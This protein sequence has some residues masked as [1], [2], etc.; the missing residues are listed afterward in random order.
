MTLLLVGSVVGGLILY[1][2]HDDILI[3]S[4]KLYTKIHTYFNKSENNK[5]INSTDIKIGDQTIKSYN[6]N[7]KIFYRIVKDTND[8][9]P[10]DD[11][12]KNLSIKM[13]PILSL[14]LNINETTSID[15][16][17]ISQF[18]FLEQIIELNKHNVKFWIDVNNKLKNKD[19]ILNKTDTIKWNILDTNFN[20]TYNSDLCLKYEDNN[21]I[22]L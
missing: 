20:E 17:C 12:L 2:N 9:E 13:D 14:S 18:L 4:L 11:K 8:L 15:M 1:N 5:K 16:S 19:I 3:N 6:I 21:L 7:N 22:I 10:T